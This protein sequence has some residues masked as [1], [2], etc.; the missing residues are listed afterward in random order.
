MCFCVGNFRNIQSGMFLETSR[1]TKKIAQA[2]KYSLDTF[3][4]VVHVAHAHFSAPP[5][6][7]EHPVRKF[8]YPGPSSLSGQC[9]L[10]WLLS[11]PSLCVH[12][13]QSSPSIT[14]DLF[15]LS[16]LLTSKLAFQPIHVTDGQLRPGCFNHLL[17]DAPTLQPRRPSVPQTP[18]PSQQNLYLFLNPRQNLTRPMP[19]LSADPISTGCCFPYGPCSTLKVQPFKTHVTAARRALLCIS[20]VTPAFRSPYHRAQHPHL[21]QSPHL[22][23]QSALAVVFQVALRTLWLD[24]R[25]SIRLFLQ[26]S[27][28]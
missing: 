13:T 5:N 25:P 3:L 19:R 23:A 24:R 16:S 14:S 4:C 2:P 27:L 20:K 21:A 6:L 11:V 1:T 10:L 7:P 28:F 22:A 8:H 9:G 18:H 17:T 12:R 26:Q 15:R